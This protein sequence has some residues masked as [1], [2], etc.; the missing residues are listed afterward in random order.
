MREKIG[1]RVRSNH[2]MQDPSFKIR[3]KAT[4]KRKKERKK[5][6][7]SVIKESQEEMMKALVSK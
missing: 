3:K 6:K 2:N 7:K 5:K 1:K 4:Q